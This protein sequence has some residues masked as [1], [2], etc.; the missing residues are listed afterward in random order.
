MLRRQGETTAVVASYSSN[1]SQQKELAQFEEVIAKESGRQ[2]FEKH[3]LL[4]GLRADQVRRGE[5]PGLTVA[6]LSAIELRYSE[7][8]TGGDLE[9]TYYLGGIRG[10]YCDPRRRWWLESLAS[11]YDS[12]CQQQ[13]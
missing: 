10:V 5:Y 7:L 3:R 11:L 2:L 4:D 1:S 12:F 8:A 13:S 9:A 6:K